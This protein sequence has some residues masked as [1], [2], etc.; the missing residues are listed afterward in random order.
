MPD[1]G[2]LAR[3]LQ[4]GA[5]SHVDAPERRRRQLTTE[6][7][8][9]AVVPCIPTPS[10]RRRRRLD[11]AEVCKNG[12]DAAASGRRRERGSAGPLLRA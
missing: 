7:A 12:V 10:Q 9:T 2:S 5:R 3:E 4:G 11:G 8:A 6:T 1:E